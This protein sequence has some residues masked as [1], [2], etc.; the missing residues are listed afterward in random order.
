MTCPVARAAMVALSVLAATLGC[1]RSEAPPAP[2]A[3]AAAPELTFAGAAKCAGCHPKERWYGLTSAAR[4]P[5]FAGA[6]DAGRRALPS[7][8]TDLAALAIQRDPSSAPTA[9]AM[10]RLRRATARLCAAA[11]AS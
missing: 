1:Q 10:S 2:S 4:R 8:Q 5:H 3:P 11:S 9:S 7:A 6:L